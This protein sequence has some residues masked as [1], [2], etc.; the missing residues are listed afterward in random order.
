MSQEKHCVNIVIH[1]GIQ[2]HWNIPL[3]LSLKQDKGIASRS[4]GHCK[5]Q[6]SES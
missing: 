6:A 1:A 3:L 4:E 5:G 2:E